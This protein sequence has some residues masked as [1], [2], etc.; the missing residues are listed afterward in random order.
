MAA[1]NIGDVLLAASDLPRLTKLDFTNQ[2]LTGYLPANISFPW[3]E[4]LTLINNDI[5]V[6]HILFNHRHCPFLTQY[7]LYTNC[8]RFS[9]CIGRTRKRCSL[10]LTLLPSRTYCYQTIPL[11]KYHHGLALTCPVI[12]KKYA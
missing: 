4:E 8:K 11:D 2:F 10:L 7:S 1:G 5:N 12:A 3:L 9:I 6:S